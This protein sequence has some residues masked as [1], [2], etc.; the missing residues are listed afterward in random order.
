MATTMQ[1][2]KD[3][4]GENRYQFRVVRDGYKQTLGDKDAGRRWAR[5]RGETSLFEDLHY[6]DL[7]HEAISRLVERGVASNI[8]ELSFMTG[9]KDPR[10]LR[11]YT[12]L[13]AR[14]LAERMSPPPEPP[15][16]T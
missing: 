14:D 3:R 10:M 4:R 1:T 13:P 9:Q 16:S 5:E 11:R 15:A 12:H 2:R 6:H 8:L 7:K